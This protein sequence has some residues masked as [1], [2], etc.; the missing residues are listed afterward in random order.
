M[1]CLSSLHVSV[2]ERVSREWHG[3]VHPLGTWP[4]VA[5]SGGPHVPLWKSPDPTA[6]ASGVRFAVWH[7]YDFYLCPDFV[8]HSYIVS[9]TTPR[10]CCL[11]GPVLAAKNSKEEELPLSLS[12]NGAFRAPTCREAF[13]SPLFCPPW[14]FA[15]LATRELREHLV[16]PPQPAPQRVKAER[17]LHLVSSRLG[18]WNP[19]SSKCFKMKEFSILSPGSS[20]IVLCPYKGFNKYLLVIY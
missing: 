10:T 8:L 7:C 13:P 5:Q 6:P 18:H 14:F 9:L 15:L 4:G 2:M 16:S 12:A 20:Q 17:R 19:T 1:V 11:L 3:A